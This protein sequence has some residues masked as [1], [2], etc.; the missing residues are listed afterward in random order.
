MNAT[1]VTVTPAKY[2]EMPTGKLD[3]VIRAQASQCSKLQREFTRKQSTRL[4]PALLEMESRFEKRERFRTDL[5]K[6]NAPTWHG[7]LKSVG[8]QPAA[9]RQWKHRS[10]LSKAKPTLVLDISV[11]AA[12]LARELE[13]AKWPDR[14]SEVIKSRT[15]LT[16]VVKQR[17]VAALRDSAKQLT[18]LADQFDTKEK[19]VLPIL[20]QCGGCSDMHSGI[21]ALA[22]S[23]PEWSDQ[24]LAEKSGCSVLIVRQART[25]HMYQ[26]EVA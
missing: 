2:A 23:N 20:G 13:T 25:R 6:L 12:E 5:K 22:K 10:G 9:Y 26:R 24:Q 16:P 18:A 14:L 21:A 4:Y 15:R 7:Y 11:S 1:G 19:V 8:V 17:L 3:S